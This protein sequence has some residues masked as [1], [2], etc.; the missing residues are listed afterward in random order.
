MLGQTCS[1]FYQRLSMC[2][3]SLSSL[4]QISHF[5]NVWSYV[6]SHQFASYHS[7][8]TS[9]TTTDLHKCLMKC[10]QESLHGLLMW[11][12]SLRS[13]KVLSSM[14]RLRST[15]WESQLY[16]YSYTQD[17]KIG[18]RCCNLQSSRCRKGI[19]ARRKMLST[20]ALLNPKRLIERLL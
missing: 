18:C 11:F 10:S 17:R 7:S 4:S 9:L 1:L 6:F 5:S 13:L 19:N 20:C 12:Y 8:Q 2:S 14:A 16:A 3:Y 15:H